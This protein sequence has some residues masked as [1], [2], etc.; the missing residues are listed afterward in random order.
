M[1]DTPHS[2]VGAPATTG[3]THRSLPLVVFC[4]ALIAC[5]NFT[6]APR[7]DSQTRVLRATTATSPPATATAAPAGEILTVGTPVA[8]PMLG[9]STEEVARLVTSFVGAF[10]RGDQT[11][12][13]AYF[14]DTDTGTAGQSPHIFQWYSVTD[15]PLRHFVA[16]NRQDLFSYFAQRHEQREHLQLRMIRVGEDRA[17]GLA[18]ISYVLT[19]RADDLAPEL[20]GPERIAQSKGAIHCAARRIVVWSMAMSLGDTAPRPCPEPPSG[21]LLTTVVACALP[22]R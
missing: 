2:T 14:P 21:T 15:G 7:S 1:Q 11:A 6:T 20:G 12:L 17:R 4:L 8:A 22:D 16:D 3:H 5:S 10:N 19:R 9:C 18:H 13:R